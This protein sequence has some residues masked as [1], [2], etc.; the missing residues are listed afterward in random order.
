[1]TQNNEALE[2]YFSEVED[3][4]LTREEEVELAKRIEQGDE[5][6]KKELARCNLRLVISIAKKYRDYGVSFL[7]LIQE[8]NLGLMRAVEKFDYTKGYKFSTY[9]TWWIRQRVLKAITSQSRTIRVPAYKVE[10]SR[11]IKKKKDL[12]DQ[13]LAEELDVSVEK[14]KLTKMAMR[15]T[16]SLDKPADGR[17][18]A[19]KADLWPDED[20]M[21]G[22]EWEGKF[23]EKLEEA[24]NK[25]LTDREKRIIKLRYGL[26]D[27]ESRTLEEVGDV[28]GLSRERIRQIQ[29]RALGKLKKTKVKSELRDLGL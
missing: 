14:I 25:H 9:A 26:D 11:K 29:D 4:L 7:D 23:R 18:G 19:T 15:G 16:I 24:M 20:L 13:E 10:L 2:N 21:P 5:E 22:E 6:A 8:G 12:T 3:V 17:E 27:Y 1:M 28:F